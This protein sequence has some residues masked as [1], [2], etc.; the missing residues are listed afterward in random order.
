MKDLTL[1]IRLVFLPLLGITLG[2]LFLYS[3]VHSMFFLSLKFR[4]DVLGCY[5]PFLLA[6]VLVFFLLRPTVKRL[7]GKQ[8]KWRE[9]YYVV[10]TLTIA[11]PT[12]IAQSYLSKATGQLTALEDINQLTQQK[13]SKYY[14]LNRYHIDTT[15]LARYEEQQVYGKTSNELSLKVYILFPITKR[16]GDAGTIDHLYWMGRVYKK[17]YNGPT[18]A[19][20]RHFFFNQMRKEIQAEVNWTDFR[21]FTFLERMDTSKDREGFAQALR[22]IGQDDSLQTVVFKAHTEPFNRR[23]GSEFLW[24]FGSMGIG[25]AVSFVL[26][27]YPKIE[28]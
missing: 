22:S 11:I 4:E 18:N 25:L 24:V 5:V 1:K 2:F 17:S 9:A 13:E 3:L 12:I 28:P 16:Y 8:K 23:M 21:Q 6:I 15:Q 20:E 14:T 7:Y 27:S 26:M 19:K 10:F